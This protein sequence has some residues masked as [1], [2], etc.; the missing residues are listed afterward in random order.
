MKIRTYSSAIY[1]KGLRVARAMIFVW[2]QPSSAAPPV[3]LSFPQ[4]VNGNP[5]LGPILDPR[6]RG[7]DKKR[8]VAVTASCDAQ[9]NLAILGGWCTSRTPTCAGIVATDGIRGRVPSTR[10]FVGRQLAADA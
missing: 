10:N 1:V 5:E 2:R 9:I 3:T 4:S 7:G 6:F 8:L